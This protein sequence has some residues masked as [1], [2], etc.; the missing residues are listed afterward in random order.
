MFYIKKWRVFWSEMALFPTVFLNIFFS[1]NPGKHVNF[2]II[3]QVWVS[4]LFHFCV[5]CGSTKISPKLINSSSPTVVK[6]KYKKRPG[7]E[8]ETPLAHP[9]AP[10]GESEVTRGRGD[11]AVAISLCSVYSTFLFLAQILW[12]LFPFK[13]LIFLVSSTA[14]LCWVF[15]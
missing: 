15:C 1:R 7:R 8:R 11:R 5:R 12:K 10:G 6:E 4:A 2:M 14:Q 13:V 9:P 3:L